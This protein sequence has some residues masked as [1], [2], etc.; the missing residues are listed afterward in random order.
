MQHYM[1]ELLSALRER[2]LHLKLPTLF[3]GEGAGLLGHR[4]HTRVVILG[5]FANAEGYKL[6]L[7]MSTRDFKEAM[8]LAPQRV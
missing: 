3:T 8:R 7:F 5:R 2:G 1:K 6:L 4:L